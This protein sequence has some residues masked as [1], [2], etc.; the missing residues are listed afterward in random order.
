VADGSF[1][2]WEWEGIMPFVINPTTGHVPAGTVTDEDDLNATVYLAIDDDYLYIAADVVD[3]VYNY[4]PSTDWWNSDALQL[5]IGLYDWRGLE[6]KIPLDSIKLDE[7][8]RFHPV[9]GMRIPIDI[10]FHDNDGNWEG[11]IGLSPNSTDHQ[12]QY[13][14]EWTYTWIGDTTDVSVGIVPDN[15]SVALEYRLY[16]NYPNPFNPA[17]VI[18]FSIAAPEK[19]ELAIYD[20]LGRKV[21]EIVNEYLPAGMYQVKWDATSFPSG[22]YIYKIKAG[23]FVET[24]KMILVK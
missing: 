2:E 4:D 10:Y 8:V 14:T 1:D 15:G 22:I 21:D 7:D 11:N 17:T 24:K 18:T 16:N 9:N 20:I 3:N 12:W 6:A 13:P 23:T 5:F 19:V